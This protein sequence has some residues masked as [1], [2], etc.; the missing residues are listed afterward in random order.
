MAVEEQDAHAA[1]DA[2][3]YPWVSVSDVWGEGW[4]G[5]DRG[6]VGRQASA[7]D[8][9]GDGLCPAESLIEGSAYVA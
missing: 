9:D 8:G 4:V 2:S 3:Y 6:L 5:F 7:D 1:A